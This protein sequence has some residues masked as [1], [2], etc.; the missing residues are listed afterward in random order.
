M[1]PPRTKLNKLL[2][3]IHTLW[4]YSNFNYGILSYACQL[5]LGYPLA[6]IPDSCAPL[7]RHAASPADK[8]HRHGKRCYIWRDEVRDAEPK[9]EIRITSDEIDR[10]ERQLD[11]YFDD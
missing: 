2:D 5:Q 4:L 6:P 3:T 9:N 8:I 7:P 10:V 11:F 1:R